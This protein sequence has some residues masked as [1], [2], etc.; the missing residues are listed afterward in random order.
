VQVYV[1]DVAA[2]VTR[3]DR[4]LAAWAHISV[5]AHEVTSADLKID[6]ELLE[7]IDA[8]GRRITEPG[9]FHALVGLNSRVDELKVLPFQV[10]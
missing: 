9:W 1:R 6:P 10:T 7:L 5:A 8:E 2:S 4:R 3:P